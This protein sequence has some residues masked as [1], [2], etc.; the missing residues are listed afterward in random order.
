MINYSQRFTDAS[1]AA[2]EQVDAG[3]LGPVYFGRTVWHRRQG[4]PVFGGWFGLQ[5]MSGGGPLMDLG[6]HRLD[7]ALWLMGYPEPV[8]V[9]GSTYDVIV[10]PL[11]RKQR[12]KFDV[13]DLACGLIKFDDGETLILE[14]S[15]AVNLPGD[16]YMITSLSGARG[17]LVHRYGAEIYSEEN[18]SQFTK[19]LDHRGTPTPSPFAEFVDSIVQGR[20]PSA[21]GEEGLKVVRSW[22]AFTAATEADGRCGTNPVVETPCQI[23]QSPIHTYFWMPTTGC[24]QCYLQYRTV[25][26]GV[27]L[28]HQPHRVPVHVGRV[29]VSSRAVGIRA[30]FNSCFQSA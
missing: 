30:R 3:A 7:L 22:K 8:A 12:R 24:L 2:K 18:G 25:G 14:A 19:R 4:V 16:D 1:M 10:P 27:V 17:G 21:T 11:A 23:D 28:T 5:A 13:E 6:V 9:S 15:W 20:P 29:R 26:S